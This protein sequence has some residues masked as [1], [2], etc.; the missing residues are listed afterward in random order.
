MGVGEGGVG[1]GWI[2]VGLRGGVRVLCG[3]LCEGV[4]GIGGDR[5]VMRAVFLRTLSDNPSQTSMSTGR[6]MSGPQVEVESGRGR[7]QPVTGAK[8]SLSGS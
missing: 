7:L 6:E 4:D 8:I 1:V 2:T 5:V 3:G